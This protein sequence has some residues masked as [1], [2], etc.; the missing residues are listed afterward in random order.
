MKRNSKSKKKNP[1]F[2][3]GWVTTDDDERALRRYRAEI[4]EMTVRF[5]GE[6]Y[7]ALFE[8]RIDEF[9]VFTKI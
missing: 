1:S 7:F 6:K 3:M 4:E 8:N 9:S 2:G 5:V